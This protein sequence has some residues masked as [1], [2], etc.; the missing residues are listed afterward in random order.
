MPFIYSKNPN[1]LKLL[2]LFLRGTLYLQEREWSLA[3]AAN[4]PILHPLFATQAH[5]TQTPRISRVIFKNICSH[6]QVNSSL[7]VSLLRFLVNT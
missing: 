1:R 3:I 2:G 5:H 6:S 7:C 4:T